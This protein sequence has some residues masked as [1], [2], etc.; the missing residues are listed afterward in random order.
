MSDLFE[1]VKAIPIESVLREY[2]PA[3]ELKQS[4]GLCPLHLEKT[5]SFHV[6][7]QAN[8]WYC[9]GACAGGGTT[10][11]LLLKGAIASTPL[12]AAK[13]LAQRFGI[14]TG[15]E[16]PRRKARA[17]TVA[18]YA[19]FCGLAEAFLR[20]T[21]DL[22]E[23]DKG[24]EIPYKDESGAVVSIQ[25]RHKLEKGKSKDRRF[26]WRKGNKPI[27]YG[28]WLLPEAK[29]RLLLVEGASDV[30]V[31]TYCGVSALGIPGASNFKPEMVSALLPFDELAL[32]QEPEKAGEK[33]VS[34][35]TAALKA[36]EY[37]GVV[38]AVSLPEKDPR[39][40]WLKDTGPGRRN[41]K[42]SSMIDALSYDERM[43]EFMAVL[44]RTIAA[45][46]PIN[47]YPSI[48][49]TKDLL[50]DLTAL[51][52]QFIFFKNERV[53]LLIGTWILAT[54]IS[55]RFQYL[56]IL[57][58]TSPVM[59]CG[60]SRLV[61]IIDK[62]VWK[63]SG[64]VINTSLAAL[65]YMT[66]EGCTFLADEVENLKNSDREQ[67]GAIIG[68]IN[69]GFA[70]GAT[71]RR[72]VQLEGEWVLKK[73]PVYGPKLLSGIATVT[74]TIRDRSLPIKMIRK[75]RKEKTARLNMR[76]YGK[77]FTDL[78]QSIGLWSEENSELI[79]KIYDDLPEESELASCDDRFIDIVEPLLSIIKFS[80]AESANG[81][82]RVID[83]LMPLL[84]QLGGQRGE[85]QSDEAIVALIGLLEVML[86]TKKE[87]F[88][89]SAELLEKVKETQGLQWIG[90]AKT[91][92]A[93]MSKLDLVSRRDPAGD[94]RGYTVTKEALDDLKIRYTP[95]IP[96]FDPSEASETRAQSG[97]EPNL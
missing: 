31:L 22:A 82:K 48:P 21:F 16:K 75:S 26:S 61:D 41:K 65:Y 94:K 88:I 23:T 47:L 42:A 80:D 85:A 73:F 45:A 78:Q 18:Q 57:W 97:R 63:S 4:K 34:S 37:K 38:K 58:I 46:A 70:K 30:H 14:D 28:L 87:I 66:A 64:S 56:P 53:A 50:T 86:G 8:T 77:V 62:L 11:D 93:F 27:P 2:F 40:L 96:E 84:K 36:A 83:Q 39:A 15:D 6:Y 25:R 76:R 67:F 79:E 12:D 24:V 91:L 69:A 74:D 32:I 10:I 35:I 52:R 51:I 7:A 92:A 72:M 44:E 3:I 60:K 89:P 55:E 17:L 71:V 5:P 13:K 49:L 33:F 68:I 59:R 29:E 81:G 90:S 95:P 19:A 54:Y 43:W 20:E 1:R 9:F